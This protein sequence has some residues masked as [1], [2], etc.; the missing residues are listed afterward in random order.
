ML[1]QLA[2]LTRPIAAAGPDAMAV[3]VYAD[4]RGSSIPANESGREGVAC[5]DDAARLLEVLC[6]VWTQTQLPWVE[7]WARA[8]LAFVLWMQ[9]PD[10]RWINF[11]FDWDGARNTHG[12]TSVTGENFWHARA[13]VGVSHAWL[14]FGDERAHDALRLGLDRAISR[15]APPD[16]RALHVLTARR[17]IADAGMV[18]LESPMRT[19]V[20]ELAACREGDV[21]KNAELETG[22][23]HLWAHIQEGVLASSA[24][25]LDDPELLEVAIRSADAL[26]AP[27]VERAFAGP[28][29]SPYD[30]GACI[31]SLDRLHEATGDGRW[32]RLAT[33]ARAWFD[34]RN[35]AGAPVY[36]RQL[37]LVADGV[38]EDRVSANSGAEA[39]IQAAEALFADAVAVALRMDDPFDAAS[40]A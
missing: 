14:T 11:V 34:G 33:D 38:D 17:L 35:A 26:L 20:R 19:W 39:N 12:I 37:G 36:D 32:S 15:P 6:D 25:L 9:E 4:R 8:M 2:R 1:R 10:G 29:S 21:L 31:Y 30:V 22:V 3:A 18:E 24:T 7:R 5:V 16:V 28:T 23:P 27:A 40:E 13:L